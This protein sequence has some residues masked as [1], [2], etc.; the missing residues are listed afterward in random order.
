MRREPG[1][2]N[3]LQPLEELEARST[4]GS[5][6]VPHSPA[7]L[8]FCLSQF[9]LYNTGQ[10]YVTFTI[11]AIRAIMQATPDEDHAF[12]SEEYGGYTP[13]GDSCR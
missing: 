2:S 13:N 8:K 12:D 1:R 7:W 3:L 6:L 10:P 5:G 9:H 11:D 4:D